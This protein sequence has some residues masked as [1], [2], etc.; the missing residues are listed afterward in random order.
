MPHLQPP[1]PPAT[2]S[3]ASQDTSCPRPSRPHR[4]PRSG[5]TICS[6]PPCPPR[7]WPQCGLSVQ[8]W[9][10]GPVGPGDSG[11]QPCA[12]RTGM[13]TRNTQT[14]SE[15]GAPVAGT[16]RAA[17]LGAG[18]PVSSGRFSTQALGPHTGPHLLSRLGFL[19]GERGD[20]CSHHIV[21]RGGGRVCTGRCSPDT[22]GCAATWAGRRVARKARMC[23]EQRG[24]RVT[25]CP[26]LP[27]S[28]LCALWSGSQCPPRAG[29][30][31]RE[32]NLGRV[33]CQRA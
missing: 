26:V 30:P 7:C 9:T 22:Q 2:V 28:T 12:W 11:R 29:E 13:G 23:G 18:S 15:T 5:S 20:P 19:P 4:L 21:G 6:L 17:Q 32:Q 3:D 10:R 16:Q 25:L 31:C 24:P 27:H 14:F 33:G 8:H 1:P